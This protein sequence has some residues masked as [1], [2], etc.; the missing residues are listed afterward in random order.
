MILL[1]FIW[2]SSCLIILSENLILIFLGLEF[3]AFS[4]FVLIG[5]NKNSL[6]CIEGVLKYFIL[7]AIFSGLYVLGLYFIYISS[8]S[9]YIREIFFFDN[10]N[11]VLLGLN[12][13]ILVLIFKLGSAPFYFWLVD[14]YESV[15]W[16]ILGLLGTLPK[17]S[18]LIVL[19]QLS[20]YNKFIIMFSSFF[21][22]LIGVLGGF[23]QSKTKRL[24]AYSSIN[25]IGLL[26]FL[27]LIN[28]NFNF[29]V[30]ILYYVIYSFNFLGFTILSSLKENNL[31]YI[32]KY[33]SLKYNFGIL[34]FSIIIIFLSLGGLP[35]LSGFFSKLFL[36]ISFIENN[37]TFLTLII[38]TSS[39]LTIAYYLRLI[40]IVYFQSKSDFDNW[41]EILIEKNTIKYKS[42][43]LILLSFFI[44][45][46]VSFIFNPDIFF[47][48]IDLFVY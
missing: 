47:L 29:E 18:Y 46:S 14:V 25:H 15:S 9:F 30:F 44:Y 36:I 42:N 48:I 8:S 1:T 3:Q 33:L 22:I 17:I 35:P 28:N 39:I 7:S 26:L 21:C 31:D 45:F 6:K 41:E 12:L 38:I 13:I 24:L 4:L 10:N 11:N 2:F 32:I 23:N 20:I 43:Y 5:S 19:Y 34:S 27:L 16:S 37:Y 40:K